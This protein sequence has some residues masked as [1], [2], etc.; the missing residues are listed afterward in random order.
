MALGLPDLQPS[1]L[2]KILR[3]IVF[4]PHFPLGK[5][6]KV[7]DKKPPSPYNHPYH[8]VGR[9][10]PNLVQSMVRCVDAVLS[11]LIPPDVD[12]LGP[13]LEPSPDAREPFFLEEVSMIQFKVG[14]K[15]VYPSHGVG[16]IKNIELRNIGGTDQSFY[17]IQ[18]ISSGATLMVPTN[19]CERA[20]MR[21]LISRKQISEIYDILGSSGRVAQ[22]TW[23]RR[24]REFSEKLR[25]G[26]VRDV[27]EVLRDLNSLRATKDL[28]F[29]EK[30]M[31]DKARELIVSEISAASAKSES[32]IECELEKFLPN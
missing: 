3:K 6:K 24:F 26:S 15:A 1:N 23:N 20:G 22:T 14:D 8:T 25:T 13:R 11:S 2:K 16:V 9:I 31:M 21:S 29:G 30:K 7:F 27:A 10:L 12:Y 18:I 32:D 17:V 28:S 4:V 5:Y 19:A